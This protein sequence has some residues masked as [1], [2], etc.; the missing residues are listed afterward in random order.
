MHGATTYNL[1]VLL[2]KFIGVN[3]VFSLYVTPRKKN[4]E[5]L[6][7]VDVQTRGDVTQSKG[8]VIRALSWCEDAIFQTMN[9]GMQMIS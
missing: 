9:K 4:L 3:E 7:E 5:R 2:S 6:I 8:K 1:L